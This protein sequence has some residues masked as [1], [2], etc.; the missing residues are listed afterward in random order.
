M[1]VPTWTAPKPKRTSHE[2]EMER[3]YQAACSA[4]AAAINKQ[5]RLRLKEE[6]P[7]E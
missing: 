5:I 3:R 4:L 1:S 7:N 2:A 6:Q